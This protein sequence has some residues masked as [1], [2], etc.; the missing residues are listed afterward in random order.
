MRPSSKNRNRLCRM[1]VTKLPSYRG[2]VGTS[3]VSLNCMDSIWINRPLSV[4]DANNHFPPIT[5][6]GPSVFWPGPPADT[7]S[8]AK[9]CLWAGECD[10]A[11]RQEP[12]TILLAVSEL[13]SSNCFNSP[14]SSSPWQKP[15]LFAVSI[16]GAVC[17][18]AFFLELTKYGRSQTA[19]TVGNPSLRVLP[20]AAGVRT[21]S[22]GQIS[23]IFRS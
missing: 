11:Q 12:P 10:C 18:R 21:V 5:F 20:R 4:D 6:L 17:D 16:V 8:R 15:V 9:Q 14:W 3:V 13:Y 7:S 23:S 2:I 22:G 19:P 1:G